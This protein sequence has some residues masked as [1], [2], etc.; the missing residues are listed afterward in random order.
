MRIIFIIFVT[1]TFFS[2]IFGQE[3]IHKVYSTLDGLNSNTIYDIRQDE[4]GFLWLATDRGL[5]KFDGTKFKHYFISD[6]KSP[7]VS[8]ILFADKT[9]WVQ[10]FN[11]QF[12]KKDK[13]KLV[14]QAQLSELGN[15][16]LAHDFDNDKIIS[17]AKKSVIIFD[18]ETKTSKRIPIPNSFWLPS[19]NSIKTK[20]YL[21]N[22]KIEKI[23]LI[24]K[25]G[26]IRS[27]NRKTPFKKEYTHWVIT[28]KDEYF[29]PKIQKVILERN[30][31]KIYD[32]SKMVPN[33]FVQNACLISKHKIAIL[34]SNGVVIFNTKSKRFAHIYGKYSCSKLIIDREGNWWISTIGKGLILI[35]HIETK[36]YLRSTEIS[37]I[38]KQENQFYLGTKTNAI[39]RFDASKNELEQIKKPTENHEIKSLF[40]NSLKNELLFCSV[41]FHHQK[42]GSK[43]KTIPISVN[44]I[45]QLDS[46]HYLL[47]ESNN[48]TIYPIQKEDKWIQW[49]RKY[50]TLENQR[51]TLL[52][53][54]LRVK[55]AFF[56]QEVIF[57][58]ASNRL[59]LI[60]K[61][62]T[63]QFKVGNDADVIHLSSSSNGLIITTGNQ[64]IFVYENGQLRKLTEL[65]QHL[66]DQRLYKSKYYN[67]KLYVVTYSGIFI[68]DDAG[69]LERKRCETT[70]IQMWILLIL[71]F[72]T[73]LYT[74][75]LPM[76][77][78]SFQLLQ[79]ILKKHFQ[80]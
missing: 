68:F 5:T 80:N 14:Y 38:Q 62:S 69:N 55:N 67:G 35:P 9:V 34:T 45:S 59:W 17:L 51:L 11:G 8:N 33:S 26:N 23:L 56:Y 25:F 74:A 29:I 50:S 28:E 79:I 64:G 46:E 78:K 70:A 19:N 18:P 61:K 1:L 76:D 4:N 47:S 43:E 21:I 15:F 77:F 13:N 31:G 71:R 27:E 2:Q 44:Q 22:S 48:L 60:T 65:N 32:F 40:F 42:K 37:A 16:N 63:K 24:D 52:D 58:L 30:T 7:A 10:N 6:N 57:A 53:G 20:F 3:S 39:Y 36:N 73:R 66:K 49:K 72:I 54:N 75:P 12:F 41:E